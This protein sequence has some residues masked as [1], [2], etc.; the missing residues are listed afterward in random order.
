MHPGSRFEASAEMRGI[1]RKIV[2]CCGILTAVLLAHAVYASGKV[3]AR[4]TDRS[5][6]VFDITDGLAKELRILARV[7]AGSVI[8]LSTDSNLTLYF[9]STRTDLRFFGPATVTVSAQSAQSSNGISATEVHEDINI[10]IDLNKSRSR[11]K[12][13]ASNDLT[14]RKIALI[15]PVD[16]KVI[17]DQTIEFRWASKAT[18]ISSY[19]FKLFDNQGNLVYSAITSSN[20]I[21][22]VDSAIFQPG[23]NYR[24]SV[25]SVS[26]GNESIPTG[27]E[28]MTAS[29]DEAAAYY[30]LVPL[31]RGTVSDLVLYALVLDKLDLLMESERIWQQLESHHPG[32]RQER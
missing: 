21:R 24:W 12:S 18:N 13:L 28:F 2:I 30:D 3:V 25:R 10:S 9:S 26:A 14:E 4:V 15:Q 1:E 6:Q 27:G 31:T 19:A 20:A 11:K 22:F 5:G 32:I 16:V 7:P 17:A 23:H 29:V 8:E